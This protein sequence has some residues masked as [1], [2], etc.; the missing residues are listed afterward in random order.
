LLGVRVS[1]TDYAAVT[2]AVIERARA[3]ASLLVAALDV[4]SLVQAHDDDA[5]AAALN[6]FDIV[7]P[8]GQPVRWGLR[9]TR[10]AALADR[11]Y[12]PTLML[13]VC[14]AAEREGLAIFLYGSRPETLRA[15]ERRLSQRFPRL[16]IAGTR[17]GRFRSL[18]TQERE[19]DAAEILASGAAIV[20]VG[21]GCPRQ[22]WWCFHMRRRIPLPLL[23]VGAAF[24]FHAGTQRQA[25]AW[26]QARGLEWAFRL[27][28]EPRRL[29]RRYLLITPRYLPLVAAQALSL[30]H[31][32]EPRALE[33]AEERE[34]PG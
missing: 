5:Y 26:L 20:F 25:P 29:W 9:W 6:T 18:S 24:D 10:Q 23:G 7:A 11:V 32:D 16:R 4:H 30:V 12:G 27:S 3:R 1:V 21:M 31:F 14:A 13:D 15:L 22:E 34:C 33:A 8:D 2:R 28:R 19:A 17:A